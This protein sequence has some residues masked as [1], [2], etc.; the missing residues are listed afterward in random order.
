[1]IKLEAV[2][3]DHDDIIDLCIEGVTGHQAHIQQLKTKLDDNRIVLKEAWEKYWELT[4][5]TSLFELSPFELGD[6]D[7]V[8]NDLSKSELVKVA[9]GGR[10]TRP[11]EYVWVANK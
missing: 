5:T 9:V 10:A 3:F 1:M 8:I 4:E 7:S 6:N 2:S 11:I